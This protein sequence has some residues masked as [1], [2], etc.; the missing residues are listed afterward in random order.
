MFNNNVFKSAVF[1]VATMFFAGVAQAKEVKIGFVDVSAVAASIPQSQQV[2]ENIRTE[3]AAKIA[4]V[5][6]L[7]TDINFNIEK[8]RRDGPTMS[9]KQQQELTASV[10][11]QREQYE[12]LAR[13]LDEQIRQRQTEERN[14][15]LGMIKVAIDVVAE[16]EKFDVV[17]NAN[18]AVYAKPE[19]DLSEKVIEQVGKAN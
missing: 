12:N 10:N 7:E 3:F 16:R 5:N 6:K 11:K 15:I 13:P 18:A 4:E 8:L 1:V 17:L 14:R 2:Q 19:Y 9:E